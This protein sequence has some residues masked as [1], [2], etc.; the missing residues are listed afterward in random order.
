MTLKSYANEKGLTWGLENG[1]ND[2]ETFHRN[3]QKSQNW[4]FDGTFYSKQ[5]MY[6]LK[7]YRGVGCYDN[8]EC[9]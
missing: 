5:K 6:E 7:S 2:L 4:D 1:M 3:T 8:E 9:Y